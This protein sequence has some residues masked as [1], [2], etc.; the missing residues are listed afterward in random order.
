MAKQ[1]EVQVVVDGKD[2]TQKALASVEKNLASL[3]KKAIAA[4]RTMGS[5]I[6]GA[7]SLQTL[8]TIGAINS[9][10]MDMSSRLRRVTAD[11]DEF[12]KVTERLGE[13]ADATWS[14][15]ESTVESFLSMQGPLADMGYTTEE[16]VNFVA[17]LNDAMVVSGA[18]GE[19]AAS[20]Q[21]ALNKAMA[22]GVLRG[23]NLNTVIEKGGRVAEALAEYLGVTVSEL[24]ALGAEGRITSGVVYE[25]IAGSASVFRSESEAMAATF[26][27]AL[28]RVRESFYGAFRDE[29][30]VEPLTDS[31][32]ELSK[33]LRDP[34]IQE[35]LGSLAAGLVKLAEWGIQAAAAFAQLGDDL[36]YFAAKI[37]GN[38]SELDRLE[39]E[40]Q[41]VQKQ[42]DGGIS[43]SGWDLI[44]VVGLWRHTI[45]K[46]SKEALQERKAQLEAQREAQIEAET[47]M[48]KAQRE[49]AEERKKLADK[50][51]AEQAAAHR[52]HISELDKFRQDSVKEAEKRGNEL[53][54]AEKEAAK[55]VEAARKEG[56]ELEKKFAAIRDGLKAGPEKEKDFGDYQKLAVSARQALA[57]GNTEKA[58]EDAL[59][60]A[61]VLKELG[62]AGANTFGF[63]GMVTSM[64]QLAKSAQAVEQ[65]N[66]EQELATI[67]EEM[68][69][70]KEQADELKDMPVSVEL[71]EESLAEVRSKLETLLGSLKSDAVIP[72]KVTG[73]SSA[74]VRKYGV[75]MLDAINGMRLP[76]FAD[77]GLAGSVA[78]MEPP[79][80]QPL[81]TLNFN[82]PGGDS[83]S[84]NTAGEWSDD[85]RK[86]AIKFGRPQ[87]R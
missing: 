33:T 78:S 11:E 75:G 76:K 66:A 57:A 2:N 4:G 22:T 5:L 20:V 23:E 67:K 52:K 87:R 70:L 54:K 84:V 21:N 29:E 37:T 35:G 50:E 25:A 15:M 8:K 10:W 55:K 72:V 43:L 63:A 48:T 12:L 69:A 77:G 47:G 81:G 13:V 79:R 58:K 26:T 9:E 82:L 28:G 73:G 19:V 44:P 17:A 34:A 85:L 31:L 14:S 16:Q 65:A 27:D 6:A 32:L 74:A 62:E 30:L 36:G 1:S 45:F 7:V 18:K 40:L 80:P 83:F 42:L 64:E 68:A 60:A 71:D 39:K 24:R 61:S 38:V 46:E 53:A 41:S 59:A 56:L 51:L 3:E 49:A 86:A